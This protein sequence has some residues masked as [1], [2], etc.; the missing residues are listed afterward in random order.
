MDGNTWRPYRLVTELGS[1]PSFFLEPSNPADWPGHF[2]N[3]GFSTLAE[4]FSAIDEDLGRPDPL[5]ERVAEQMLSEGIHIRKMDLH[6]FDEDLR[7]IHSVASISFRDNLL[8]SPIDEETF[9]D[10]YRPLKELV[11]C[12]FVL[13]AEHHEQPVGF[14]FAVPDFLQA[15][16]GEPID[17]L[18]V[19]TLAILPMQQYAGLGYLMLH[20]T[21][22]D[23]PSS[24]LHAT[25]HGA[26]S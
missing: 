15:E 1:E 7:K 24:W 17:T 18:I 3:H 11:D 23:R 12:D 16:R 19:K 5:L 2:R 14:L 21:R 8:F 25:D 26:G 20:Q 4:Y 22:L 10:L 9:I 6:H 13:L